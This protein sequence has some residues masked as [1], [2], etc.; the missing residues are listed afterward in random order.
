MIISIDTKN[1]LTYIQHQLMVKMLRKLG[2]KGNFLDKEHLQKP[3]ANIIL[4]DEK[5]ETL[6][7]I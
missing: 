6:P 5:P 7:L 2:L 4:N 3:T 1:R